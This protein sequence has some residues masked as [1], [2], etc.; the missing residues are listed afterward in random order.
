MDVFVSSKK[1]HLNVDHLLVYR[2]ALVETSEGRVGENHYRRREI[3]KA[4]FPKITTR[5]S[6]VISPY[7]VESLVKAAVLAWMLCSDDL[8]YF[9]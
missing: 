9:S 3:R 2:Q 5:R 1:T 8:S 7:S 6:L 4:D